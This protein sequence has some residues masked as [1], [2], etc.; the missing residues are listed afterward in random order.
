M[1][2][3][4]IFLIEIKKISKMRFWDLICKNLMLIKFSKQIKNLFIKIFVVN[5]K[6]IILRI[7][8]KDVLMSF[9]QMILII[10]MIQINCFKKEKVK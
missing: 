4:I 7:V 1:V 3:K 9:L 6:K 10:L 5:L 8:V 2:K